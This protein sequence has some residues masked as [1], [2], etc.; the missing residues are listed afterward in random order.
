M[1]ETDLSTWLPIAEAAASIGCSTRTVERLGRA[2]QLEQR[3][4]RQL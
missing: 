3:L 4:R 2:K 1:T